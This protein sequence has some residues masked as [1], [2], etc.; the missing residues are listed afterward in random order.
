ME[1]PNL[2]YSTKGSHEFVEQ[3]EAEYISNSIA[4]FTTSQKT[5]PLII[6]KLEEEFKLKI[7][8][9]N[10]N[11]FGSVKGIVKEIELCKNTIP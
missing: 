2:Y 5:R 1:Y 6:A 3:Y 11:N 7:N 4:G 10:I 8:Q 9:D